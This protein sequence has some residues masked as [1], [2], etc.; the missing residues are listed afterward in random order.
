MRFIAEPT[1]ERRD[2]LARVCCSFD[3]N[4]I[5]GAEAHVHKGLVRLLSA[6]Y[7][8]AELFELERPAVVGRTTWT[9][10]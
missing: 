4:E 3:H 7:A 8:V 6:Q 5:D 1:D 2:H 9:Q 10:D